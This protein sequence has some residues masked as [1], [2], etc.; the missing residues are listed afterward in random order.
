MLHWLLLGATAAAVAASK[1]RRIWLRKG[2]TYRFVQRWRKLDAASFEKAWAHHAGRAPDLTN[3]RLLER[4]ADGA[5]VSYDHTVTEDTPMS[6]PEGWFSLR[7][8][9][10]WVEHTPAEGRIE[11]ARLPEV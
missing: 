8:A 10:G 3:L 5:L 2:E 9:L 7:F 6:L 4:T 11:D 1:K